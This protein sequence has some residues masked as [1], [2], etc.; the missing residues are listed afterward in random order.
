MVILGMVKWDNCCISC[1]I[2]GNSW[3]TLSGVE[4]DVSN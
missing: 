4:G 1:E 3:M 2:T